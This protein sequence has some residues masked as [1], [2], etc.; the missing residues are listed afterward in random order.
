MEEESGHMSEEEWGACNGTR[1]GCPF[2]LLFLV[3]HVV[4]LRACLAGSGLGRAARMLATVG[5]SLAPSCSSVLPFTLWPCLIA[6]ATF[7]LPHLCLSLRG[8][9]QALSKSDQPKGLSLVQSIQEQHI[10]TQVPLATAIYE[11][12]RDDLTNS[13]TAYVP[14]TKL[15]AELGVAATEAVAYFNDEVGAHRPSVAK[16]IRVC[17]VPEKQNAL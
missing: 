15:E 1:I 10:A 17:L 5:R 12:R 14:Q 13:G 6:L 3:L 7:F 16:S 4:L 8:V 2:C 9:Q 11:R